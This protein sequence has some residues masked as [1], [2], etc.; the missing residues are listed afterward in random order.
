MKIFIYKVTIVFIAT[1]IL[2]KLTFSNLIN[3]YEKKILTNFNKEGL[4]EIKNKIREELKS[5]LQK[6]KIL[7]E[8]DA[9]LIGQ[10]IKKIKKE[11]LINEKNDLK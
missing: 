3:N 4:H 2:F 1:L 11:I 5:S 8:D 7:Y 6:D 10:F 9:K